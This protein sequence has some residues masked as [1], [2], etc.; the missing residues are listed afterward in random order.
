MEIQAI[1]L[2]M[3]LEHSFEITK[4]LAF[5]KEEKKNKIN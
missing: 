1:H 2:T 5:R 4:A 3:K